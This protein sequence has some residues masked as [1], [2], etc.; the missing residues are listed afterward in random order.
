MRLLLLRATGKRLRAEEQ[1][2]GGA[3][4][5][6]RDLR[7]CLPFGELVEHVRSS[8]RPVEPGVPEREV[9]VQ[10]DPLMLIW[11]IGS[12]EAPQGVVWPPSLQGDRAGDPR[13]AMTCPGHV[14]GARGHLGR[15]VDDELTFHQ[16]A[17]HL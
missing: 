7:A 14:A 2:F 10:H 12:L 13:K 6:T 17:F 5:A 4:L 16:I 8:C 3:S 11:L 9:A 1:Q 15:L